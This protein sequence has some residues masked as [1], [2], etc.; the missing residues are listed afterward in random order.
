MK[1]VELIKKK[2]DF[3][4]N[5][6]LTACSYFLYGWMNKDSLLQSYEYCNKAFNYFQ[7]NYNYN[8]WDSNY[9]FLKKISYYSVKWN[10]KT[11]GNLIEN[12]DSL[13]DKSFLKNNLESYFNIIDKDIYTSIELISN[14]KN[15]L[16]KDYYEIAAGL[17]NNFGVL[18]NKNSTVK[19]ITFERSISLY[20]KQLTLADNF[21][22][23]ISFLNQWC[24]TSINLIGIE[25][26]NIDYSN[27][28]N[29]VEKKIELALLASIK[30]KN[31]FSISYTMRS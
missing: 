21:I 30:N 22:D 16:K 29:E 2:V 27:K 9:L 18:L 10:C 12:F 1:N 3:G 11:L 15:E 8:S 25:E 23:S 20:E 26:T 19:K 31:I 24:N 6:Y 4:S 7:K 5:I 28:I 13:I 14:E 17:Y